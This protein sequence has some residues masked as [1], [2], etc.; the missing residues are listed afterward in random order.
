[1]SLY[2]IYA[3]CSTFEIALWIIAF[4]TLFLVVGVVWQLV[5][6]EEPTFLSDVFLGEINFLIKKIILIT[7]SL[8]FAFMSLFSIPHFVTALG[9][10]DLRAKPS[11]TYC[12][13]VYATNEKDKTYT[14]PAN[15]E[16]INDNTYLVHNV[17]FKN[18]GYL[19]FEDCDYFKYDDT[20]Y[21]IDQNGNGWNIELTSYKTSNRKVKET[22]DFKIPYILYA[23]LSVFIIN[24]LL[25]LYHLIKYYKTNTI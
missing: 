18:G 7:V 1:M 13:Y 25:H 4:L 8:L 17:Y 16:K 24:A 2:N 3:F 5:K 15:I 11:G 10:E 21:V 14:L 9:C 20:E 22:T 19:Y 23:S 6:K 12:Y